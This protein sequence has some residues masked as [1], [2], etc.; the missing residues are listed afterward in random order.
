MALFAENIPKFDRAS[1]GA[2]HREAKL[3]YPGGNSGLERFSR[4]ADAAQVPLN[5]RHEYRNAEAAKTLGQPLQGHRL[6]GARS[7]GNQ[8]VTVRHSRQEK[9]LMIAFGDKD[10]V[11][12]SCLRIN[13]G[14]GT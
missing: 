9:N 4:T 1:R 3:L 10:W 11:G 6:A 14:C 8:P 2:E 13:S 12:H 7:A 5:V